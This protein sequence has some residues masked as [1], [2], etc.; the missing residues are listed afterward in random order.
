MFSKVSNCVDYYI[1][2]C[3]IFF[4]K[5]ICYFLMNN[6]WFIDVYSKYGILGYGLLGWCVSWGIY[7]EIGVFWLLN[8]E[9][10]N[11]YY[12][13]FIEWRVLIKF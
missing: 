3:I 1:W 13:L 8:I 9:I 2:K 12:Y 7:Y 10:G 4:F 6:F 5:G 11:V